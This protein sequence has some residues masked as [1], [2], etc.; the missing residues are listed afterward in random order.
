MPT[1]EDWIII[2]QKEEKLGLMLW[3]VRCFIYIYSILHVTLD[4]WIPWFMKSTRQSH[5]CSILHVTLD[6]WILW[7]MKSTQ[8]S[9]IYIVYI[10][11]H[12]GF[13]DPM[14]YESTQQSTV[15]ELVVSAHFKSMERVWG[16]DTPTFPDIWEQQILLYW[17]ISKWLGGISQ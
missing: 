7:F 10:A 4:L 16:K 15:E 13:M 9:H 1:V 8:Q 6:L 5:I 14:I 3:I 2:Q 17:S 11:C 12:F